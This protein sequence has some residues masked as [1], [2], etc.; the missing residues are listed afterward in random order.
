[1]E[2]EDAFAAEAQDKARLSR[3]RGREGPSLEIEPARSSSPGGSTI[4]D[5][6]SEDEESPLLPSKSV[7]ARTTT[8]EEDQESYQRA[9]NEPWLGAQGSEGLPWY[10]KPSVSSCCEDG[11]SELGC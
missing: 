2:N 10:K 8:G 11:K 6:R 9:I 7:R 3:R 5:S 4:R 1:M